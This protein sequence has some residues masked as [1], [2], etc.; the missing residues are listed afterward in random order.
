[1]TAD[2]SDLDADRENRLKALAARE[3]A[4][5]EEEDKA[6]SKSSKYTD[7]GNF[8]KSVHQKAGDLGLADRIGRGRQGFSKDDD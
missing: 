2:A 4:E 7:K 5:R 6:R 1:M 3:A 8:M